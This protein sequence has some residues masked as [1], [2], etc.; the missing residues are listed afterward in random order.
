[1]Y[2]TDKYKTQCLTKKTK[3][4]YLEQKIEIPAKLSMEETIA[5]AK[6]SHHTSIVLYDSQGEEIS[7]YC[8][9][10]QGVIIEKGNQLLLNGE[11]LLYE[12]DWDDDWCPCPQGVIIEKG[13][14][15]LCNGK[16]VL[17][18]GEKD[19]WDFSPFGLVIEKNNELSLIS[20]Y[21][22][23]WCPSSTGNFCT[24]SSEKI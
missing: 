14:Q 10:P 15:L 1:M 8:S 17:Y 5:F 9:H 20:M 23:R 16:E 4:M 6:E 24:S 2:N 11:I 13:D 18:E 12:G 21:S 7:D 22:F 19:S 3:I